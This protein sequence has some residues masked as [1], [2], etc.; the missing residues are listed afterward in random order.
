M[1]NTS[2]LA[3]VVSLLRISYNN[4]VVVLTTVMKMSRAL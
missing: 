4:N 1:G 2:L 3:K